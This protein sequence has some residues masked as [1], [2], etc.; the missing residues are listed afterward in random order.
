MTFQHALIRFYGATTE[1]KIAWVDRFR[2]C[3]NCGHQLP[4][5]HP[6]VAVTGLPDSPTN[7]PLVPQCDYCGDH[8]MVAVAVG[9]RDLDE[10]SQDLDELS[11]WDHWDQRAEQ[12]AVERLAKSMAVTA[13]EDLAHG[14]LA[15]LPSLAEVYPGPGAGMTGEGIV[16]VAPGPLY[17]AM[18]DPVPVP[19]P[20]S[21]KRRVR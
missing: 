2:C 8:G 7:V 1:V 10:P 3:R 14:A 20:T 4:G 18:S 16:G 5:R 11:R 12:R 19:S 6:A 17:L 21:R 15:E 9:D 13:A